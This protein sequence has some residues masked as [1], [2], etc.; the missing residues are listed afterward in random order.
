MVKFVA[1]TSVRY[2][3]QHFKRKS[4][5]G[6]KQWTRLCFERDNYLQNRLLEPQESWLGSM[7]RVRDH[8]AFP[9]YR[10][11]ALFLAGNVYLPV[12]IGVARGLTQALG[13]RDGLKDAS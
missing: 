6:E 8:G 13:D 5:P 12:C 10:R 7:Q 2:D 4:S 11:V 3:E 1:E 9:A